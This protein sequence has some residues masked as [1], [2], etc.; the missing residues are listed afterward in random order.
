[1]HGGKQEYGV[2]YWETYSPVVQWTSIRMFLIL[3]ILQN[4]HTRQLDFVL[5]YPQANTKTEQY[6]DMP[7]G[8]YVGGKSNLSHA[9]LLIKSIYGGKASGRIWKNY[10]KKGLLSI[11]FVQ[12]RVEPCVFYRGTLIFL[13]YVDDAL[14][15]SPKSAKVDKFIQDLR[16]ANFKVTDTGDINN[17]LGVK[18]TKSTDGRF[19]LTQPHLIQHI[20]GDLGFTKTTLEKTSPAP[21]TK[22]LSRELE[23]PRFDVLK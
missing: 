13:H 10:L 1:M 7:A 6:I 16:D 12:S 23:G 18:V 19:E 2:H 17:Y 9:L 21:S 3:S 4:W 20:L 11:G 5:V 14:C 15:L 22:L 8:F